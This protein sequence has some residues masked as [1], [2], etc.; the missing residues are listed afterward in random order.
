VEEHFG[1][2]DLFF[3]LQGYKVLEASAAGGHL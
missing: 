1:R 3:V 2:G